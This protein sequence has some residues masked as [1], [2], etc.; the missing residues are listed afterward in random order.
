MKRLLVILATFSLLMVGLIPLPSASSISNQTSSS[1]SPLTPNL[2]A[3]QRLLKLPQE[4]DLSTRASSGQMSPQGGVIAPKQAKGPIYSEIPDAGFAPARA[5]QQAFR[6]GKPR[7]VVPLPEG[8]QGRVGPISPQT[9]APVEAVQRDAASKTD[10][11]QAPNDMVIF[12][13]HDMTASESPTA[14]RTSIHEPTAISVEN[15]VFYTANWF[16]A[17]STDG[18]QNFTYVSPYTTF[19]AAPSGQFCCDQVTAY[20][21]NQNMALWGLQY[22][23][24]VSTGTFRIARTIGSAGIASNVWS[25]WDFNPQ[26]F[27]YASGHWMDFPNMTVSATY[28]YVASNVFRTDNNLYA[29]NVVWRIPLSE[30]AAGGSI[31]YSYF[32]R[33]DI[34][35]VR[36]AENSATTMYWAAFVNSTQV[37]LHRWADGPGSIFWDNINLNAYTSLPGGQSFTADGTNWANRADG[38]PLGAYVANGVIGVLWMARQDANFP[39]PYTIHARFNQ[40]T[41]ALIS[42]QQI[43]NSTFAWLYPNVTVNAAG[44]LGGVIAYGGGTGAQVTAYPHAAFWVV[45]DVQS[46]LPMGGVYAL[47][48]GNAGPITNGWGD[49][50]SVRKHSLYPNTWVTAV[51]A[52]NG[53]TPIPRYSWIGRERDVPTGPPSKEVAD[54]DG[55]G[56]S[57]I[58]VFR[59]STGAWYIQQS[60]AGFIAV[61][62]GVNGDRIAPADY[63]G[64]G[65]TDIAVFRPS[66]GMWYIQRSQLGFLAFGFGANGDLPAS[67]DFDGDG[68]ADIA[69]FR[70]STGAWY[71]QRSSLGFLGL[72]FGANGD[73][74]VVADY[75]GDGKSDVAVYRQSNGGWYIQRSQ[76]GFAAYAFGTPG[77]KPAPGDFDGDGKADITVFRPANGTWYVQ[78]SQL[79]FLAFGFGANGDKPAPGDYD[80]DNK[81]DYAIFRPSTGSWYI[82]RSLLG[83]YG[84][85]FGANGDT[86]VAGAYVP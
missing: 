41:S 17:R 23:Q 69:V 44:N 85:G 28:L 19:P 30:L 34:N 53:S 48:S 8:P 78:R 21:P 45:D 36:L 12:R 67:G 61:G 7:P 59:P 52:L 22:N 70:P 81:S 13:Q 46:S 29:G 50:L 40:S 63:D 18:G 43:W 64:D 54:F 47:M 38:R 1:V 35:T 62:F 10:A 11:P 42:Q 31:N 16:A 60:L 20:A 6:E 55:D 79:G 57:D 56:K 80:G 65:R 26:N 49:Y 75:D 51:F 32:Q 37:R 68:K 3:A 27:G 58:G 15:A 72:S 33:T 76:L 5:E 71:I 2:F 39:Q 82:Q 4:G 84:Q 25:Y 83:F 73:V 24:N 86:P 77:D 66:T 14:Q 9:Q 74:P